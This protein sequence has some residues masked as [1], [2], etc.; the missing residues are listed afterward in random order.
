MLASGLI[1]I[2]QNPPQNLHLFNNALSPVV[3]IPYPLFKQHNIRVWIKRDDLLH[4]IISGNKW[5]KLKYNLIHA[6]HGGYQQVVS[7]G[8]SYSNHIHALAYAAQQAGLKSVGIIRGEAHHASNYTLGWARHWGMHLHF[9][10][11]QQYRL[12]EDPQFLQELQQHYPGSYLIPEGGSN[13]LALPGMA[14]VIEQLASQ[15]EFDTLL[16]PVGSGGTLAGL[17]AADKDQHQLQGIAVLKQQ[18]YLADAVNQLLPKQ[19]KAYRN[20]QVQENFHRGGYARFTPKDIRRMQVFIGETGIP[21]EPVY[22]GK[23]VLALLDMIAQG[24]F[25][26]G[27]RIVLLHTGGLQGLGGMIERGQLNASEWHLPPEPPAR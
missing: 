16:V 24:Q 19:A 2:M 27:Q 8:G 23:M 26:A 1:T 10:N 4:P 20:W 12:R 3:R 5:R 22:S 18:G 6:N 21:L 9:V 15:L 7:F 17:V 11:R 25:S 14:E 13:P